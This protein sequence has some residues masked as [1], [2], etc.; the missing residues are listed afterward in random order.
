MQNDNLLLI[1]FRPSLD[2]KGI[3]LQIRETNVKNTKAPIFKLLNQ[4][5]YKSIFEVNILAE[6]QKEIT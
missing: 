2:K 3:L 6:K 5:K 4:V 1:F